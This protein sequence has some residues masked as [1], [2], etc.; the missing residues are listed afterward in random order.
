MRIKILMLQKCN[1]YIKLFQCKL[2]KTK[3]V[4][5]RMSAVVSKVFYIITYVINIHYSAQC[6][7]TEII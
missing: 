4:T 7:I 5:H 3:S 6:K 1:Y 2:Y